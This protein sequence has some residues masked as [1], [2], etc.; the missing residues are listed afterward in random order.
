MVHRFVVRD[1]K[2]PRNPF[3]TTVGHSQNVFIIK[4]G[5]LAF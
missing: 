2:Q 1:Y 3:S 4:K 5:N